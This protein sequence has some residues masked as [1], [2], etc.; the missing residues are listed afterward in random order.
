MP[1]AMGVPG[2]GGVGGVAGPPQ[3]PPPPGS[4]TSTQY[5]PLNVK[6]ALS[7]LDEVKRQFEREPDVYNRF[8][9]IMKDFKAM[10]WVNLVGRGER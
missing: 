4:E 7:Y 3:P 8:L 9:D 5:R 10:R 2:V 1:A 6:D